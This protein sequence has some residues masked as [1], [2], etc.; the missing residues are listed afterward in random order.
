[1]KKKK[2]QILKKR[3]TEIIERWMIEGATE[4]VSMEGTFRAHVLE[5]YKKEDFSYDMFKEA[6]ELVFNIMEG[7]NFKR[8]K[9]SQEFAKLLEDLGQYSKPE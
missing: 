9:A 6:K 4:E 2:K 5:R 7:D 3:A 1:M 8:Y